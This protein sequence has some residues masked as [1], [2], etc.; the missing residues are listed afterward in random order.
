MNDRLSEILSASSAYTCAIGAVGHE[1]QRPAVDV[2]EVG[3]SAAREGAQ[4]VQR[5]RRLTIGL[6]QALQDRARARRR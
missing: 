1:A 5:R 2:V 3:V 6:Q 4:Q